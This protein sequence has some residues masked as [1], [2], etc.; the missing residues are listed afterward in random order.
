MSGEVPWS[1]PLR[2]K[3]LPETIDSY[4]TFSTKTIFSLR[5][6]DLFFIKSR[7]Y[8][9]G[10]LLSFFSVRFTSYLTFF[11]SSLNRTVSLL[12]S[13]EESIKY[14]G[15]PTD[16]FRGSDPRTYHRQPQSFSTFPFT[17]HRSSCLDCFLSSSGLCLLQ[18]IEFLLKGF[19]RSR[20]TPKIKP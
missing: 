16:S 5:A 13:G 18:K 3:S 11:Y 9:P 4:V 1:G 6:D 14:E 10:N 12:R 8:V 15:G 17:I 19:I 7:Y 2:L 20:K